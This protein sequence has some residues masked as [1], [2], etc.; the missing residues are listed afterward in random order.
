[1][2]GKYCIFGQFLKDIHSELLNKADHEQ[3]I[4]G[5]PEVKVTIIKA[6]RTRR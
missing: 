4:P 2:C 1:M 6:D 5:S 3:D